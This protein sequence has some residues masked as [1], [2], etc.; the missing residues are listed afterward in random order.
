M[1]INF[2]RF[3]TS[4]RLLIHSVMRFRSRSGLRIIVKTILRKFIVEGSILIA[5]R[6]EDAIITLL[7]C[8]IFSLVFLQGATGY[9]YYNYALDPANSTNKTN[10]GSEECVFLKSRVYYFGAGVVAF[11]GTQLMLVSLASAR[12]KSEF[13]VFSTIGYELIL[14]LYT[15]VLWFSIMVS[16]PSN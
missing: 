7:T 4:S 8:Q 9:F 12:K 13:I 14:G 1:T 3:Q 6:A 5:I 15:L 2:L 10:S 16:L 11:S